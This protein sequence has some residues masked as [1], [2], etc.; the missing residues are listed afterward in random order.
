MEVD[1]DPVGAEELDFRDNLGANYLRSPFLFE[2]LGDWIG[3]LS[4]PFAPN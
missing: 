1:F 3:R 4:E 2:P